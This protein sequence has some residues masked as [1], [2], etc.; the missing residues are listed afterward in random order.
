MFANVRYKN[1]FETSTNIVSKRFK[2]EEIASSY[3]VTLLYSSRIENGQSI[4]SPISFSEKNAKMIDIVNKGEI[5]VKKGPMNI[6]GI[7][8]DSGLRTFV[9]G[10]KKYMPINGSMLMLDVYAKQESM[11]TVKLIVDVLGSKIEYFSKIKML[12]GDIW[13]NVQI[14]MNK[15][16]TAEGMVLKDYLK[17]NA[18]EMHVEGSEY[19][20]NNVLWV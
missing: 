20:I 16:K 11:L 4:F 10:S 2:Q 5:K 18:L 17:I 14:D 12:G 3:K 1:G 9:V 8:C 15:F 6:D 13:Q 7:C 19:L